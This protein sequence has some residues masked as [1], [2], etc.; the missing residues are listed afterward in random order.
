MSLINSSLEVVYCSNLASNYGLIK[1]IRF[2]SR[3]TGKLCNTF[4]I[5]SRFNSAYRCRK[6]FRIL[7]FATKQ[8]VSWIKT[9]VLEDI[10]EPF[11][12]AMF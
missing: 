2:V 8:G 9:P 6:K 12:A 3:F 1:F 10:E 5:L 4:F 7:N 11:D